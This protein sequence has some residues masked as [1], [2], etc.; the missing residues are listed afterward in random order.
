MQLATD[1]N[2]QF[3]LDSI[4]AVIESEPDD[5]HFNAFL[6]LGATSS[7]VYEATGDENLMREY[8]NWLIEDKTGDL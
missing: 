1:N 3:K 5:S 4:K 6:E 8:Y 7:D 2:H